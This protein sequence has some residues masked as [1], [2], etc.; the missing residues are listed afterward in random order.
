MKIDTLEL[1]PIGDASDRDWDKNNCFTSELISQSNGAGIAAAVRDSVCDL[2]FG[3]DAERYYVFVRKI[4]DANSRGN[5]VLRF[6]ATADTPPPIVEWATPSHVRISYPRGVFPLTNPV[7][8]LNG[9]ST[10][11]VPTEPYTASGFEGP[12]VHIN[13]QRDSTDDMRFDL[14]PLPDRTP[15]HPFAP[16][17]EFSVYGCTHEFLGIT[18]PTLNVLER[19]R[20][21]LEDIRRV[22]GSYPAALDPILVRG[23]AYSDGTLEP[24]SVVPGLRVF[25]H[26]FD[27]SYALEMRFPDQ[28][29]NYRPPTQYDDSFPA[30]AFTSCTII[31]L[32]TVNEIRRAGG[33]VTDAGDHRS[34]I[35]FTPRLGLYSYAV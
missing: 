14:L 17:G 2:G 10:Q 33:Y 27:G 11:F 9:I 6:D 32:G 31:H 20:E 8:R 21:H 30:R 12:N 16:T 34:P 7:S 4:G 25:Y 1:N 5:L 24:S 13:P 19:L 29:R 22:T 26:R 23:L 18:Q 35:L 15:N 3:V 28:E